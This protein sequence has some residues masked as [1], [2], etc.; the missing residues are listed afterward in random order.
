MRSVTGWVRRAGPGLRGLAHAA[1]KGRDRFLQLL[2]VLAVAGLPGLLFAHAASDAHVRLV[3]NGSVVEQRFDIALRDLDRD[4][5]LDTDANDRLSWREVRDR[6]PDIQA[7][8]SAGLTLE[9][10]GAACQAGPFDAGDAR[11]ERQRDAT[12][13]SVTRQWHCDRPP[14]GVIVRYRLFADTDATH[15]GL[16]RWS[17]PGGNSEVHVL[18]PGGPGVHVS[19]SGRDGD[20]PQ[21][22][23]AG[24]AATAPSGFAGF[25]G[26]GV[27]HILIGVDHILFL[28]ALLLP[29]VRDAG[30][31][32][33]WRDAAADTVKVVTAFTAAHSITLALAALDI[34]DPPARWVESLIAATVIAAAL[35]N[36]IP[37]WGERVRRA[38]WTLTFGFGLVHGFGFA[39]ALKE[40]GL[41]GGSI[42]GPLIGFNLGVE[43]G[44]LAIVAMFL[45]VAWALR[46]TALYAGPMLKGGSVAIAL[47]AAV[48]LA[49]RALDLSLLPV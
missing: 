17:A 48:W 6:W 34:V 13:A 2:A 15:R 20:S 30:P 26:E 9:W 19:W 28:L 5:V 40:L 27:H 32:A 7:L 39:G 3:L 21:A 49:E 46:G 33:R 11:L 12:Y 36:L 44:Q 38:R 18:R 41:S 22:P 8:A 37:A 47:L 16:L 29:V 10:Q 43:L 42:V 25:V 4:L 14:G 45:P 31:G 24:A 35:A 23:A 1:G